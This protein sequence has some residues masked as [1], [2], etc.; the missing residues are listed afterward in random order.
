M[1]MSRLH[2]WSRYLA[3]GEGIDDADLVHQGVNLSYK[4]SIPESKE[5]VSSTSGT[6]LSLPPKPL[7]FLKLSHKPVRHKVYFPPSREAWFLRGFTPTMSL[8]TTDT[9]TTGD[10]SRKRK[11]EPL[12]LKPGKR[13]NLG[14][15]L[16][17]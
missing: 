1:A 16:K 11:A 4:A 10:D 15:F 9:T 12:K 6:P 8:V 7:A 17:Y 5:D 2:N 14:D 3:Q 13:Q